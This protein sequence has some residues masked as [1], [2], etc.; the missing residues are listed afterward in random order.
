MLLS[1]PPKTWAVCFDHASFTIWSIVMKKP[2]FLKIEQNCFTISCDL[3]FGS[4][5]KS[6]DSFY[7]KENLLTPSTKVIHDL[8]SDNKNIFAS[9]DPKL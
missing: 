9:P 3:L 2:A 4:D 8:S 5:K 1:S 6:F 7:Q